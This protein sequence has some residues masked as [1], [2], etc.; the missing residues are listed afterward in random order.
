MYTSGVKCENKGEFVSFLFSQAI[1]TARHVKTHEMS[2]DDEVVPLRRSQRAHTPTRYFNS[3]LPLHRHRN[4]S[5]TPKKEVQP[6]GCEELWYMYIHTVMWEFR[7]KSVLWSLS[8]V[9]K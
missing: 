1:S 6:S 3:E 5:T 2:S 9:L 8:A 7:K 4:H